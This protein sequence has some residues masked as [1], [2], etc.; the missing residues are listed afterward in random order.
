MNYFILILATGFGAGYSPI[1]PGTLGTLLAIPIYYF[2]SEMSSPLYEL[3]LITFFFLSSWISGRAQQ[4]F[5]KK[6]D[7]RIVIDEM[8]GFFITVLWVTKTPLLILVGF[9][10][11]RFF[12]ILKPFPI[13]RFEKVR[14]GFG[15]VLDDVLAG[16]YS[17]IILQIISSYFTL[18]PGGRGAG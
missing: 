17:N 7:Q 6:D 8:M 2:L 1:A 4:Y 18:S 3:T 12:D 16:I 10:L 13:R 5:G 11:F 15:V 9:I 14:G